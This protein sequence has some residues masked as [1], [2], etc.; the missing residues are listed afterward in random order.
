MQ[1]IETQAPPF[2]DVAKVRQDFPVLHR[3]IYDGQPLVYLDN[4][5]TS[6]KPQAVI[7]RINA[8]Y[9]RENSNIHRGVH[10]L[11][12]EATEMYEEARRK[13]ARFINAGETHE[14]IFTRGTTESI[15]LVAATFGRKKVQAGDEIVISAM[16][17]H[18][19][20]VPWQLL[21]E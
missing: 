11:S 5:A 15:N 8:Y 3:T 16:E 13:V 17:H 18:S 9:S 10:H 19:N 6:Q 2:F 21:C 20:I 14:V 12:Q 1:T 4:A 7:D